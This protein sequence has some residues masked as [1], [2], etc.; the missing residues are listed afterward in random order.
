MDDTADTLRDPNAV[1]PELL[2]LPSPPE[3]RRALALALMAAVII[4]AAWLALALRHDVAYFFAPSRTI[5]LGE[6][7]QIAPAS[8]ESNTH[9]TL[10]GRPMLSRAV[11]YRRVILGTS[12]VVYPLAGQRAIYVHV[13]DG[14]DALAALE[15]TGRLVR[16]RD[17]G[18]RVSGVA[19]ALG[20]GEGL[21]DD[22]FVLLEGDA[23]GTYVWA[24]FLVLF[25][26]LMIALNAVLMVRW[27]RPLK[28][29]VADEA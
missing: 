9:V 10:T 26:G 5:D 25:A 14:P 28:P 4:G 29:R 17:L 22:A 24:L 12:Y 7:T 1:D 2:A 3:G 11:R 6:A 15:H 23:P 13:E 27:F 16:F 21:G 8:L 20:E 19:A 18:G